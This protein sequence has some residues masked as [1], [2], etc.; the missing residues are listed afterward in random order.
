MAFVFKDST[1]LNEAFCFVKGAKNS[2]AALLAAGVE[3]NGHDADDETDQHC[4]AKL[5]MI[6]R[7]RLR[8]NRMK[9][10]GGKSRF[11]KRN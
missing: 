8:M 3:D 10:G 5:R 4:V 2:H 6:E 11:R 7:I 1:E 9:L